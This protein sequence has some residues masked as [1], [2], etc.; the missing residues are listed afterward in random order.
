MLDME[1]KYWYRLL[2]SGTERGAG[3]QVRRH[4]SNGEET[5]REVG[6]AAG[7][8]LLSPPATVRGTPMFQG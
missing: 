3:S 8:L 6:S 4:R 2:Y 1:A 7:R 5:A